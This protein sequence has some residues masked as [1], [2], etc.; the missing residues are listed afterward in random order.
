M[1]EEASPVLLRRYLRGA[2]QCSGVSSSMA[3]NND[4]EFRSG[5]R[6]FAY[7]LEQLIPG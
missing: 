6:Q 4:S 2:L 1:D 3:E 5:S 7:H